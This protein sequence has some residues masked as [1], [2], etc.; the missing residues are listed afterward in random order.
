MTPGQNAQHSAFGAARHQAGR[1]RLGI[2]AAIARAALISEHR[3]LPFEAE[4]R[5]VDVRLVQQHAGVVHQIAGGEVVGAV[6]DDVVILEDLERVLAGERHFVPIEL[7][8]TD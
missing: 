8:R 5:A 7:A 6:D 1:R 2:Q 3:G 4:N